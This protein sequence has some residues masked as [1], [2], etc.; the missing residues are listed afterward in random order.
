MRS[1]LLAAGLAAL[2]IGSAS[3]VARAQSTDPAL[4]SFGAGWFDL[5]QDEGH[6][7]LNLNVE[8]RGEACDW[9]IRPIVGAA[10]N[11]DGAVYGY[12]GIAIDLKLTDNLVLT[13]S[14]APTIYLEGDSKDLGSWF[15]FRSGVELAY[16]F[17]DKSRLGIALHHLSNAGIGDSNPGTEILSV[18]YSLP[19]PFIFGQ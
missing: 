4:W 3:T 5:F 15:E 9:K 12:G 13:P 17:T 10:V 6:Q 19:L 2:T 14:F 8:W 1:T 16:E 7:T 18:N 11:F